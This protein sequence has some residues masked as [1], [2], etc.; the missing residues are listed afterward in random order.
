MD[1][2]LEISIH[3]DGIK[4]ETGRWSIYAYPHESRA[5]NV[6]EKEWDRIIYMLDETAIWARNRRANIKKATN[7]KNVVND[8]INN[9]EKANGA[10]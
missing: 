3:S 4:P 10:V 7:I 8:M 5:M 1:R 9:A 2:D 6:T